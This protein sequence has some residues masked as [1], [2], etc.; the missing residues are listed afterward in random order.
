MR[1]D[2]RGVLARLYNMKLVFMRKIKMSSL[3]DYPRT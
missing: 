1:A 3:D 2:R